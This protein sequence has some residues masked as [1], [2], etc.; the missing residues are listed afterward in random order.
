M[1]KALVVGINRYPHVGDLYGCV[2]DARAVSEALETDADGSGNINFDVKLLTA[3]APDEAVTRDELKDRVVELFSGKPEIAL[4][5]FAGHGHIEATGGY[6]CGSECKRGD[7]GLSLG[8]VLTLANLSQASNKVIVLDSCHSGVAGDIPRGNV[9]E[10]TQGTTILTAS[11]KEQYATERN[12]S[13]VFTTLFVDALNGAAANLV[14][15]VTPGAV[16]AHIDQTLGSWE[17]RPIFKTNV[18]R[19][20]SLR[21]VKPPIERAVLKRLPE[22]FPT[23]DHYFHSIPRSRRS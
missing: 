23:P 6:L 15:E 1:R 12:G 17:Q 14:G 20:V 22:F 5:Y 11:T 10:L 18:E 9:A 4:L 3:R 13:G 21:K 19:F 16:Y 2:N 8:E 7:D